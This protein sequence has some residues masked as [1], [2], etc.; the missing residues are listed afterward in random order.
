MTKINNALFGFTEREGFY[1]LVL[2][3]KPSKLTYPTTDM[4]LAVY[5]PYRKGKPPIECEEWLQ[6]QGFERLIKL[7]RYICKGEQCSPGDNMELPKNI[8]TAEADEAYAFLNR[9][10]DWIEMDLPPRDMYIE[11]NSF[12]VRD[13]D[14]SLLGVVYDMGHTRIVAV[15]PETRGQGLG[16]KLYRA[17]MEQAAQ[18][19]K[20]PTF[21]EWIRPDNFESI[22][23]FKKIGF[24]KDTLI[25]DCWIKNKRSCM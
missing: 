18:D 16:G 3:V 24:E 4:P 21:Y 1:K 2:P 20:T 12:C 19:G 25:T 10:F 9:Y 13:D 14:G 8:T 22:S 6:S 23:M 15:S 17:Y 5:V 11:D 7:E